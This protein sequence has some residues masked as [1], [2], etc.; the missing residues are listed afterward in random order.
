MD[1]G[2]GAIIAENSG[3]TIEKPQI[4]QEENQIYITDDN[5]YIVVDGI[6]FKI[7]TPSVGPQ[8]EIAKTWYKLDTYKVSEVEFDVAK[9][10]MGVGEVLLGIGD[11][12]LP[13]NKNVIND[14]KG[15]HT[16][17]S[18]LTHQL[19]ILKIMELRQL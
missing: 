15:H 17:H 19:N 10:A 2:Y 9:A 18:K 6:H 3:Q 1:K 13:E 7:F 11:Y 8:I 16:I 12:E 5:Q 4:R 14:S